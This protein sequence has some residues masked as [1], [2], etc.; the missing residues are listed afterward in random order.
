MPVK[1]INNL[2][3]EHCYKGYKVMGWFKPT[4]KDWY[5]EQIKKIKNGIVVEIGVYGG[6]SILSVADIA[7]NNGVKIYGIDPWEQI[8][9]ANGE[10]LIGEDKIILQTR[11]L[12]CRVNLE[13]ILK[14]LNY[15]NINLIQGKSQ[16]DYVINKFDDNSIDIVFVDGNHSYE[17]V[18]MDLSL[19]YLK[20]KGGGM[21]AGHDWKWDSVNSAVKDFCKN[22]GCEV[23]V[24]KGIWEIKKITKF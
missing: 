20:V 8:D 23:S 18:F 5:V 2:G 10:K 15:T 21:I 12:K 19:W 22:N 16:D 3:K 13:N 6:A 14:K 7:K 17:S 9:E 4:Q 1:H 11:L 24:N